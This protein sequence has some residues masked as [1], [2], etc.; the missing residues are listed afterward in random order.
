MTNIHAPTFRE[1]NLQYQTHE[2]LA[3]LQELERSQNKIIQAMGDEQLLT[4]ARIFSL[5]VI[6]IV[7]SKD[8]QE[9]SFKVTEQFFQLLKLSTDQVRSR[10]EFNKTLMQMLLQQFSEM[11]GNYNAALQQLFQELLNT[12]R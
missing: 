5:L 2:K 1:N 9:L 11:R 7:V 6:G 8:N 3:V 4:I 12:A 10:E